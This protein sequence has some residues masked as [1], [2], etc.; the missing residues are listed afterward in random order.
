MGEK[1]PREKKPRVQG[2]SWISRQ[3]DSARAVVLFGD[4]IADGILRPDGES[5]SLVGDVGAYDAL[6]DLAG[7]L[8]VLIVPGNS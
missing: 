2:L 6:L 5:R 8:G 3:D 1:A 4:R 7:R